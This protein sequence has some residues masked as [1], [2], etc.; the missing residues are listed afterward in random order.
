MNGVF[1]DSESLADLD[2]S[3]LQ[4]LFDTFE[5]YE[6]TAPQQTEERI[7][8]AEVVII[9]KVKLSRDII[10][11]APHLKLIC[12]VA[13]GTDNVDCQAARENSITVCNCQAYG[14][15]SVVQHVFAMI[16]ALHTNLIP[17]TQAVNQGKWQQAS[18]FCLL[19]YPIVELKGRTLGI[20]G[21]GNLGKG[22]ARIGEAFG[23]YILLG[24]RPGTS[25]DGRIPLVELLPQVD[26]L[27]LHCPLTDQT[28]NLIDR[29]ALQ[30]MK[31]TSFLINAARGG[32]VEETALA[33][34]LRAGI[35]AGAATDVLTK[36]PP[37]ST[38]PLLAADIPNLIITPHCAWGSYQ[39]RERI[40][41]Q[42]VDN[43]TTFLAGNPARVVN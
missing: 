3:S 8:K 35:I 12:L 6:Q 17:Y 27:T 33:D 16:L 9:N 11:S 1:L 20:I 25:Q 39:A 24:Q 43:I 21:Y 23:M 7:R 15:D 42:T 37:E 40:V 19:D 22:V 14:T 2:L 38:N 26:V 5:I 4:A 30:L 18:Q 28:R 34:A 41:S 31:P 36:E 29:D 13:T 10:E 32:I